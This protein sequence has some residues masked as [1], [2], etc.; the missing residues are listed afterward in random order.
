MMPAVEDF[1]AEP[2]ARAPS[3]HFQD[4]ML[5][6][7]DSWLEM[8][9]EADVGLTRHGQLEPQ[10]SETVA[11]ETAAEGDMGMGVFDFRCR[12]PP[13]TAEAVAT[14]T[15]AG[16]GVDIFDF[17]HTGIDDITQHLFGLVQLPD[18]HSGDD[19]SAAGSPSK[20]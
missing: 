13:Q 4:S 6:M 8:G 19:S 2:P 7:P 17:E 10:V 18:E 16:G 20:K 3:L 5:N 1:G 12:T 15:E 9:N 11:E 14:E